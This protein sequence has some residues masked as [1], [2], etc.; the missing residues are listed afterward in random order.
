MAVGS[1]IT[2][3]GGGAATTKEFVRLYHALWGFAGTAINTWHSW[4]RNSSTMLTQ[5]PASFAST[6]SPPNFLADAN[7]LLINGKTKLTKVSW[8]NRDGTNGSNIQMYIRSFT[9]ANGTGRGSE[10]NSQ[11][12]VNETWTTP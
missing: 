3:T 10:T 2:P 11:V 12:L 8:S 1:F 7:F 4:S 5:N 9:Y 6:V